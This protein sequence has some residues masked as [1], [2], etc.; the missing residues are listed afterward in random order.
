MYHIDFLVHWLKKLSAS[1]DI[2][3]VRIPHVGYMYLNIS[4]IKRSVEYF[5]NDEDLN[6]SWK[7]LLDLNRARLE[8]FSNE[9][10]GIDG[11]NRHKKKSKIT[12]KYFTKGKSFKELENWQNK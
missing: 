5:S 7:P 1:P 11:H 10:E 9:F 12:N 6:E 8:T 4:K 2:L 3:N